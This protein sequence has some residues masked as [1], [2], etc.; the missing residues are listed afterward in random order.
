MECAVSRLFGQGVG[1]FQARGLGYNLVDM[2]HRGKFL[3][4][5]R[6][7]VVIGLQVR[8]GRTARVDAP[9]QDQIKDVK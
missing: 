7:L 1:A 8:T 4:R 2:Q 3:I 5:H 9:Q 6:W